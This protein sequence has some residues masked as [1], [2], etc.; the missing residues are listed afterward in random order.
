MTGPAKIKY[1]RKTGDEDFSL[2]EYLYSHLKWEGISTKKDIHR[3]VGAAGN[4][5]NQDQAPIETA[6]H[7]GRLNFL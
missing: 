2:L 7:M 6:S 3:V 4:L 5:R 1:Y